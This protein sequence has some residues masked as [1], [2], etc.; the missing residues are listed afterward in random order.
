MANIPEYII[1]AARVYRQEHGG[2]Q[3]VEDAF[4]A[5]YKATRQQPKK[6]ERVLTDGEIQLFEDC[7]K[8]YG[9]KGSK[10]DSL[11]VWCTLSSQDMLRVMSHI[12]PYISSREQRFCK[13]FQRYL[14]HRTFNDIV[15]DARGTTIY[16][17]SQFDSNSYS[18]TSDG[19]F[20]YW[21]EQNKRLIF[22]GDIEHLDDGYTDDTR[23]DGAHVSWSMY[24]WFWS[25][26]LKKWIKQ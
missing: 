23:P 22:N 13:D 25:R 17:P 24:D 26:E 8:A 18:P 4:I 15:I 21:D 16:D 14:L 12:R 10:K 2:G 1:A 7:W 9:R 20:Q 19:I 11:S 5:G 3:R 6:D